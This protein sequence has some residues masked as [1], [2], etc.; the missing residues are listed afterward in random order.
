MSPYLHFGHISPVEIALAVRSAEHGDDEDKSAYL[1]ELIVRRELAMNHVFYE[2][3]YDSYEAVPGWARRTLQEHEDDPRP[4]L[5]NRDQL[6]RGET[7]DRYW[8]AS[9]KEIRETGYMHNHMRMYWGKKIL[10][11]SPTPHAAF[12]T[13]L[14]INNKFF[15]DGRD[16]NS[17]TNVAWLF[18]LHDRPWGPRP[19]FGIVRSMGQ[20]TLKK[21]DADAYVQT[22]DKLASADRG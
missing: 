19:V 10:E 12:D 20:A 1:E 7:H 17:F 9:M 5:Y 13:T 11:W 18:G 21:F 3:H 16:A 4:H 15:L 2:P 14:R 6:E 8:N 22:V